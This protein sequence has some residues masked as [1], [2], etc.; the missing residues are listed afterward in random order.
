MSLKKLASIFK[1]AVEDLESEHYWVLQLIDL[2]NWNRLT[3][4][5]KNE[6]INRFSEAAEFPDGLKHI[7]LEDYSTTKAL[8]NLVSDDTPT[9]LLSWLSEHPD[10]ELSKAAQKIYFPRVLKEQKEK[11]KAAIREG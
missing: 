5:K 2:L 4:D 11:D 8:M 10:E 7:K 1:V 9:P 3:E 6:L